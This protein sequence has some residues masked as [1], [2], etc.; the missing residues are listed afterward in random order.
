MPDSAAQ[1][2]AG[3]PTKAGAAPKKWNMK[4][5]GPLIAL[6]FVGGIVGGI[7]GGLL[8]GSPGGLVKGT[9]TGNFGS[10]QTVTSSWWYSSSSW[11]KSVLPVHK[12]TNSY[13]IVQRPK[14]DQYN[15]DK[16][17][18]REFHAVKDGF[19]QCDSVMNGETLD[20]AESK[21]TT[22]V[23]KPEDAVMGCNG[24]GHTTMVPYANPLIGSY[25]DNSQGKLTVTATTW[26]A[27]DNTAHQIE[28]H[29]P[30]FILMQ[31]PA[32]DDSNPSKWSLIE[33]HKVPDGWAYCTSV[34]N[35]DTAKN[36]FLKDTS[37][38]YKKDD[39]AKGCNGSPFTIIKA[40]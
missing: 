9:W 20:A 36:T 17:V 12:L 15:P 25:T 19:G 22:G 21:D 27:D 37:A 8:G 40:A 13:A 33:F 38:I 1:M 18:K 39:A 16:Y 30:N 6:S 2:E 28:A 29:A 24:Y 26:K 14:N 34:N 7:T 11:G 4:L 32:D 5:W 35:G 23:Y 3:Q 10:T 31:N